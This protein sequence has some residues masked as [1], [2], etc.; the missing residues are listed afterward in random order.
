MKEVQAVRASLEFA[1]D[2]P[3]LD[4]SE[5]LT[6]A[7]LMSA[8]KVRV[9]TQSRRP[10]SVLVTFAKSLAC[11]AGIVAVATLYFGVVLGGGDGAQ[12]AAS[13]PDRVSNRMADAT[14]TLDAIRKTAAEI[15]SLAAAVNAAEP[16]SLWERERRR[17]VRVLDAD[18]AAALTA[19]ERNPGCTRA[20]TMVDANLK[21]Q[22][23]TLRALYIERSL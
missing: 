18:I 3:E 20:S 4:P 7:I 15:Q 8:Q 5:D 2:A 11:A 6:A 12:T 1:S 22:A 14:P 9:E 23:E 16:R 19:L 13:A 21:R 17:T 10:R